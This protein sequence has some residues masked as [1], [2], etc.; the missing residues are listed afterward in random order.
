MNGEKKDD[1]PQSTQKDQPG[2]QGAGGDKSGQQSSG[3]GGEKKEAPVP[4][5]NGAGDKT[6]QQMPQPTPSTDPNAPKNSAAGAEQDKPTSAP[7][8]GKDV[9]GQ[10]M[11]AQGEKQRG[12]PQPA[13]GGTEHQQQQAQGAQPGQDKQGQDKQGQPAA[14]DQQAQGQPPQPAPDAGPPIRN[15]RDGAQEQGSL[16]GRLGD[17]MKKLGEGLPKVP[18]NFGR[19]DQSMKGA[20]KELKD[21]DSSGS[22][23]HQ[24]EALKELEGAMDESTKQIA[25][26]LQQ[27]MMN[28][29][30][31][32]EGPGY[33]EGFDPL[34]RRQ[35]GGQG[36]YGNADGSGSGSDFV[37]IPEE[38]ERRRVQQIIEELR[39]RSNDYTRPKDEREYIDRLLNQFE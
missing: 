14:G 19:A 25:E 2:S 6:G 39:T 3:T 21:G 17:I 5:P 13:P 4:V 24:R 37:K 31:P 11:Q 10:A 35:E 27:T 23:P 34:G 9:K 12:Q 33:G 32:Q 7:Q 15:A 22:L 18:D 38:R 28:F 29:G 16:R 30:M 8:P 26:Q 1:S 20:V 36:G